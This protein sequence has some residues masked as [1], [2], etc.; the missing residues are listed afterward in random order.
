MSNNDSIYKAP[1]ADLLLKEKL[2]ETFING[3]LTPKKLKRAGWLALF[4]MLFLIPV[5]WV[6]LLNGAE[7]NNKMYAVANNLFLVIDT[8]VWI[9]LLIVLKTFLNLRFELYTTD[10]Y[11]KI[12]ILLSI[13]TA[14]VEPFASDTIAIDNFGVA[15]IISFGVLIPTGIVTVLF[16]KTLLS[17]TT[18]FKHLRL[19]AWLNMIYGVCLASLIL[20]LLAIPFILALSLVMVLIFFAAA[21]ELKTLTVQQN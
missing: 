6:A 3:T 14:L 10:K 11:I 21:K 12:M 1:D 18:D 5:L 4:Y 7:P 16:G 13:L 17:V 8:V 2:P 9:Y 15:D 20:I 19:F